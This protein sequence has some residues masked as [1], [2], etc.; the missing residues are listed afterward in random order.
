MGD[1]VHSP[2]FGDFSLSRPAENETNRLLDTPIENVRNGIEQT[3]R[4]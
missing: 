2:L 1:A 4:K 3:N